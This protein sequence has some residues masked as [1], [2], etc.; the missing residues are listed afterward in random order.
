[1]TTLQGNFKL[2][3]AA[4]NEQQYYPQLFAEELHKHEMDP[5]G[6]NNEIYT[7]KQIIRMCHDFWE[8]LPDSPAIRRGPFFALCNIAERI[9]D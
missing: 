4:I 5:D 6:V 7:D 3:V 2:L 1:M 9:F 8:A